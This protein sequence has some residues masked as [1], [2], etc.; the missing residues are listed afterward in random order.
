M[1]LMKATRERSNMLCGECGAAVWIERR[2]ISAGETFVRDQRLVCEASPETHA[3][4]QG[5]R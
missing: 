2:D 5:F 1:P 3:V 4:W